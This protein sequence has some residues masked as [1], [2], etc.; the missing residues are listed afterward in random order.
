MDKMPPVREHF[1]KI[2]VQTLWMRKMGEGFE[3]LRTLHISG[4]R[5]HYF[6]G[7]LF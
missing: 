2:P 1:L 4:H 7:P 6:Y 3:I 5:F